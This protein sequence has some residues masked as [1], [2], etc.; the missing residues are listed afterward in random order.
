VTS[1]QAF[2][3]PDLRSIVLARRS[4]AGTRR[5]EG[6]PSKRRADGYEFA[7]LRG[8]MAGDDPRRIDWAASAR[9]GSLQTRVF[10]EDHS[11]LWATALD[12][13]ASMEVGRTQSGSSLAQE[14]AQFWFAAAAAGDRCAWAGSDR[15][16]KPA[17]RGRT[18]ARVCSEQREAPAGSYEPVLQCALNSLPR[19]SVLLLVS[20]FY[21]FETVHSLLQ[22]CVA[23]FD[24]MALVIRDPWY[25]ELPLRGFTV[26]RDAETGQTVR[27]FLGG[28]ERERY[29][30]AVRE[31][32]VRT[33][34]A[35]DACGISSAA[36]ASGS[37]EA[38]VIAAALDGV[39]LPRAY[40]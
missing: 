14:A 27:L 38:A 2:R 30:K 28:R 15:L 26:V 25:D 39:R 23:R 37:V 12:P 31:R 4:R 36:V 1:L 34:E 6:A 29:A 16:V 33:I 18:A 24:T 7:E 8:Y 19:G 10:F 22:S 20:D 32:E 17:A 13:S 40:R 9:A 11:L 3:R 21:D 35:L 5:G